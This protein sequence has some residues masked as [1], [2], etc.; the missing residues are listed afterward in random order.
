MVFELLV[1]LLVVE[2]MM[3][4]YLAL[5]LRTMSTQMAAINNKS[6]DSKTQPT[7]VPTTVMTDNRGGP[8]DDDDDDD[9]V[10]SRSSKAPRFHKSNFPYYVIWKSTSVPVGI[11]HCT[12]EDILS[13]LPNQSY[14]AK[15]VRLKGARTLEEAVQLFQDKMVFLLD[16]KRRVYTT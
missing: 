7:H 10:R 3:I 2:A 6:D 12:W 11:Y 1:I 16:H 13:Y 5:Q 14:P 4:C 9:F 15:G 8:T